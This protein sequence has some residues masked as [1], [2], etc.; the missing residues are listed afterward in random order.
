MYSYQSLFSK[1][2]LF[3][4]FGYELLVTMSFFFFL[5]FAV[6]LDG[7]SDRA[8]D[9]PSVRFFQEI[10]LEAR[11]KFSR[12]LDSR[13]EMMRE[14]SSH[15]LHSMNRT[16]KLASSWEYNS[17]D[18]LLCLRHSVAR[19]STIYA[20]SR[21]KSYLDGVAT[22]SR[23]LSLQIRLYLTH[24]LLAAPFQ[25]A[26]AQGASKAHALRP[27]LPTGATTRSATRNVA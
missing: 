20:I 19:A 16:R 9:R 26:A 11:S 12:H 6:L 22:R 14:L 25:G 5:L 10:S 13:E 8:S 2:Y 24:G 23:H 21:A 4:F 17:Q 1:F 3:Q 15:W 18:I 7:Q 27:T